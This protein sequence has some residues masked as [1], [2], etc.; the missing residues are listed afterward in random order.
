[1]IF[2]KKYKALDVNIFTKN[3]YTLVPIRYEDR[4][5][6]MKW[7]NEQMYHLR[8]AEVLIEKSQEDYFK[9]TIAQLFNIEQPS[10]L[11]FSFL[12]H[13][14]LIGYGGLVHINWKKSR[15]EVSFIMNTE[16]EEKA[17]DTNWSNYLTIL[18]DIAFNSLNF[19]TLFTYA[20]NLRPQL[21][22]TLERNQFILKETLKK[23][24]EI[25]NKKVDVLIHECKNPMQS[26]KVR[27]CVNKDIK[28][29]YNWSND[30][31]VRSQ[32]FNSNKITIKEHEKWFAEKV[33]NEKSLILI[34][35]FENKPVGV[36]R[37]ELE[38]FNSLIGI[39]ID[40]NCRGKGL[41]SYMLIKSS[42][43]YFETFS[44]PILA[45]IKESNIASLKT[46]KKAGFIFLK[47][48]FVNK[49]PCV[50]YKLESN[51]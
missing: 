25:N 16:L 31:L 7:R 42:E 40:K 12:K 33:E 41:S 21:Y 15:A 27:K 37:F 1:M 5:N 10:Q 18:K 48:D 47:K 23:K 46:F 11:L 17:F 45:Y 14:E 26:L 6:I 51:G 9:N 3:D 19:N 34:N 13:N 20:Y 49:F 22:T 44:K 38:T 30:K 24:V 35:E 43:K 50:V 39:L 4:L 32:S 29:L 2:P 36:V 28:L 8:Q